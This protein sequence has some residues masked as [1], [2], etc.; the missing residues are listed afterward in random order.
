MNAGPKERIQWDSLS[1][2][3]FHAALS[4]TRNTAR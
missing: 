1:D 4:S 2:F 3:L